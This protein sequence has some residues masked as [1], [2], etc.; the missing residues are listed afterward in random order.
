M[1]D[2]VLLSSPDNVIEYYLNSW[3]FDLRIVLIAK[4]NSCLHIVVTNLEFGCNR[5]C[6]SRRQ[7]RKRIRV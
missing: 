1:Y 4:S 5:Y 2:M 3:F 7:M 6:R